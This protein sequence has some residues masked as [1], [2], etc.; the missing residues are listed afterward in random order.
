MWPFWG[1]LKSSRHHSQSSAN[2]QAN[3][4]FHHCRTGLAVS[5][6]NQSVSFW[7]RRHRCTFSDEDGCPKR[8]KDG[9]RSAPALGYTEGEVG[10]PSPES[11]VSAVWPLLHAALLCRAGIEHRWRPG[12]TVQSLWGILKPNLLFSPIVTIMGWMQ[13]SADA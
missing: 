8:G 10:S 9:S 6:K 4:W 12:L 1:W 13:P 7:P 3:F 5:R 11:V 2:D